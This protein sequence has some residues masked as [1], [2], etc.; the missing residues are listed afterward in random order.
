MIEYQGIMLIQ[1]MKICKS[2]FCR[3]GAIQLKNRFI[4]A[5]STFFKLYK[6][7]F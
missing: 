7:I 2:A 5:D 3:N 4:S 6:L 1:F